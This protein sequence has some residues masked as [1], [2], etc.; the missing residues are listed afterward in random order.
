M[1]KN[2]KYYY[3]RPMGL[4]VN[5]HDIKDN[6]FVIQLIKDKRTMMVLYRSP[7]Y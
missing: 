2:V 3:W 7:E 4:R 6:D 5:G 1:E